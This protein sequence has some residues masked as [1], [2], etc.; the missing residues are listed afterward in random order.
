MSQM[1]EAQAL[2]ERCLRKCEAYSVSSTLFFLFRLPPITA[3]TDDPKKGNAFL[4]SKSEFVTLLL[5]SLILYLA[6]GAIRTK[7]RLQ[8]SFQNI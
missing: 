6:F 7:W 2:D 8:K 1:K 4:Y 3:S 5:H